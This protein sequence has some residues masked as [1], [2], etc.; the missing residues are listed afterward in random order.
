MN[1]DNSGEFRPYLFYNA[2]VACQNMPVFR[3][4]HEHG[5][6]SDEWSSRAVGCNFVSYVSYILSAIGYDIACSLRCQEMFRNKNY[7]ELFLSFAK[8]TFSKC[9]IAADFA[10]TIP[11]G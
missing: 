11:A 10:T 9:G 3:L 6:Y 8:N 5:L 2:A 1:K 4:S 7:I